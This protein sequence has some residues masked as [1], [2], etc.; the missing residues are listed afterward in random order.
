[1]W[2]VEERE[3]FGSSYRTLAVTPPMSKA[4][5]TA[6]RDMLTKESGQDTWFVVQKEIK[7]ED[8]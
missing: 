1:M 3:K 5:A 2:Y 6:L 8:N 4:E 7:M